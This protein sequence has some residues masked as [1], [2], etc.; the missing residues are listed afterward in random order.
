M[1][2]FAL[3]DR[4]PPFRDADHKLVLWAHV[5]HLVCGK[6]ADTHEMWTFFGAVTAALLTAVVGNILVQKW[7]QRNWYAQQRQMAYHEEL[8]ALIELL[9]EITLSANTRLYIMK[10]I[11]QALD[12]DFDRFNSL[13]MNYRD[14]VKDWNVK[15]PSFFNR[16]TFLM[17]WS[18][19]SFLEHGVQVNFYR[20]G[21]F[22]ER[23]IRARRNNK[24]V[25]EDVRNAIR[26]EM[27]IL[28]ASLTNM[29][30]TMNRILSERKKIIGYGQKIY[31]KDGDLEKY[32]T[33]DL[34]KFLFA[35]D[36]LAIYII[37]PA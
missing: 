35:R 22:I 13:A 11:E 7:Q 4:E 19:T 18:E 32:S 24:N 17:S 8:K 15:L 26:K 31:Y 9:E 10:Q 12:D 3:A 5:W 30:R 1:Q 28:N 33:L 27:R 16:T 34:V 20:S 2:G 21:R 36:V 29:L 37:R 25:S 23:A 6:E 14:A